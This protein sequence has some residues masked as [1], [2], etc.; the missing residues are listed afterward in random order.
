MKHYLNCTFV[1]T[2]KSTI[3]S[4]FAARVAVAAERYKVFINIALTHWV[5]RGRAL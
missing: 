3:L 4:F 2:E 1:S 5:W